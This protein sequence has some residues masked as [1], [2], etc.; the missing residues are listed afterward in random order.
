MAFPLLG[1]L[2]NLGVSAFN[3]FVSS[4]QQEKEFSQQVAQWHRQNSYN[5]PVQ[6]RLRFQQAGLN[7]A[8]AA[9]EVSQSN[10]AGTLS[11]VPS[12]QQL[13]AGAVDVSSLVDSLKAISEIEKI[14]TE[15]DLVTSNIALS[16]YRQLAEKAGIRG[17]ELE[18][19]MMEIKAGRYPKILD[20]EIYKNTAQGDHSAAS[21]ED[22][23]ET[24]KS[25][26]EANLAAAK[27]AI[28]SASLADAQAATEDALRQCREDLLSA[29]TDNERQQIL[30][31]ISD[32]T[33][34]P[35]MRKKLESEQKLIDEQKDTEYQ[36]G[37][38]LSYEA[39]IAAWERNFV[40][41]SADYREQL[42][43]LGVDKAKA[44]TAIVQMQ[45]QFNRTL[46][47]NLSAGTNILDYIATLADGTLYSLLAQ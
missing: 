11:S 10:V 29:Q 15:T 14:A 1:G 3:G 44:E 34:I 38:K 35:F 17:K 18:N 31:M 22:L 47:E 24:R 46:R 5:H 41:W 39:E 9:S 43:Q 13:S 19:M 25:R 2:L 21:A 26:I 42:Y 28:A 27:S 32:Q 37:R 20:S 4:K 12:S 36:R 40:E 23:S 45:E 33:L 7:P 16:V 30:K 8:A 6:Q